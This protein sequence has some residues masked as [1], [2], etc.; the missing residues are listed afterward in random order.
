MVAIDASAITYKNL[1]VHDTKARGQ[2]KFVYKVHTKW[3]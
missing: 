2:S 3:P 1:E